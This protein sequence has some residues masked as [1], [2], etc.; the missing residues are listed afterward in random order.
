MS[1]PQALRVLMLCK[2]F[3]TWILF[4]IFKVNVICLAVLLLCSCTI[5]PVLGCE[6]KLFRSNVL[7]CRECMKEVAVERTW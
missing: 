7:V 6:L 2:S 5:A 1:W 3:S 4:G